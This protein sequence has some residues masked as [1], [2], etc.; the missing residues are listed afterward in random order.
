MIVLFFLYIFQS[1]I[2]NLQIHCQSNIR[3]WNGCRLEDL[4]IIRA[5]MEFL[6]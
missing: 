3:R 4:E 5:S 6:I 2:V 1:A